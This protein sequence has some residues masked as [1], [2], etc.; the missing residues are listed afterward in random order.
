MGGKVFS[1]AFPLVGPKTDCKPESLVWSIQVDLGTQGEGQRENEEDK[2]SPYHPGVQRKLIYVELS[3]CP[4]NFPNF[5]S[6]CFFIFQFCLF[7]FT[8]SKKYLFT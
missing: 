1:C 7:V 4:H 5:F 8:S 2:E 6:I 3:R